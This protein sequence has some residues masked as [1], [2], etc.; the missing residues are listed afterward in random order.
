MIL[1]IRSWFSEPRIEFKISYKVLKLVRE[2]L[3]DYIMKP[4][5]LDILEPDLLIGLVITTTKNTTQ[6]EVR[7]PE[8][9]KRNKFI[10]YGLWL[11]YKPITD[12]ESYMKE[13]LKYLFEALVIL[14]KKYDVP[15]SAI[16]D[17]KER[18]QKEVLYNS[19]Y[20]YV[21]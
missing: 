2:S 4:F 16:W 8:F 12:A 15:E 7:G 10:N 14:F 11:P 20:N 19:T 13:F 9:D 6:L 18:V 3:V 5:G 1:T 21:E 17:V